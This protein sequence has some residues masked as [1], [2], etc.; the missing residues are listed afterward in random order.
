MFCTKDMR[1]HHLDRK[2]Q[3]LE[4]E[5]SLGWAHEAINENL[6]GLQDAQEK[7]EKSLFAVTSIESKI[8]DLKASL[9]IQW[10]E[11]NDL[12]W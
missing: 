4:Y 3:V 9:H 11:P 2:D 7:Y 1:C 5:Q 8:A 12:P 6:A 10:I